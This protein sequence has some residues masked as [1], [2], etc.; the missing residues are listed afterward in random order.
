M[1]NIIHLDTGKEMRGG[2]RQILTLAKELRKRGHQQMIVCPAGCTLEE[3][4]RREALDTLALPRRTPW[5][6]GGILRLRRLMRSRASDVIHAHDGRGQAL[7]AMASAGLPL[8]RIASRRVA[9]VPARRWTHR[10]KYNLTC[11]GIIAVSEYVRN[12]L[13]KSDVNPEKIA[14]IPDGIDFPALLPGDTE[15]EE[16]RKKWQLGSRDFVIGHVGA[17]TEEKGQEI[18]IQ[19]VNIVAQA[20]HPVKLLLAGEG[21]LRK[22]LESRYA[23]CQTNNVV[24]S[25]YVADLSTFF[26][27][28]DLFVMPS[29]QEGL[30]S[31][32]LLAMAYGLPVI[33]SRTGGLPEIVE[34]GKTGWL[35]EPGSSQRLAHTIQ[36]AIAAGDVL[37]TM[38]RM[39]REVARQ[40]TG[41]IMAARTESFYYRVLRS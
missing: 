2:Q 6:G 8:R 21:P 22:M 17:F 7:A 11:D 38:G 31:S 30:G 15:R 3:E 19:A 4:S 36:N 5:N 27:C 35:F 33:A 20:H 26:P 1:L 16:L 28:L 13:I 14:V 9:F 39:A 12:L 25:G 41:D 37:K 10:L 18:A 24:F 32:A 23:P 29:R 34:D 40:F